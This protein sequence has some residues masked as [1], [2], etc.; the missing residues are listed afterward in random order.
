ME[1]QQESSKNQLIVMRRKIVA[2][3]LEYGIFVAF[4]VLCIVLAFASTYFLMPKNLINVLR[5]ISINGFLSIGMTFVILT[6]GI[7]LSVGSVLAFGGIVGASLASS[8]MR[9][10]LSDANSNPGRIA[11]RAALGAVT[12]FYR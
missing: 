9:H 7:D 2:L 12:G 1:Q 10:S 6:G 8:S 11:C 5:Q 4:F 3:L